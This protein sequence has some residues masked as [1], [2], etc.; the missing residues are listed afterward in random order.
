MAE[1]P[2]L[3]LFVSIPPKPLELLKL[4]FRRP[5]VAVSVIRFGARGIEPATKAVQRGDNEEAIRL[6]G[7]AVLGNEAY[8]RLS[9]ARREQIR[10]NFLESEFLG[11][12]FSD[13]SEEQV[14][15]IRQPTMLLGGK[16]SP[17]LFGHLLDRLEELLPNVERAVIGGSSHNVHEDNA[18]EFVRRVS[19]FLSSTGAAA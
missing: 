1:P 6:F 13:L 9:D 17:P 7:T 15:K 4:A 16:D 2:V 5:T 14:A 3:P 11:S 18:E 8:S 10:A 19:R 12:G